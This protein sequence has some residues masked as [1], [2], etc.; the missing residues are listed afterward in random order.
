M[1]TSTNSG[2]MQTYSTDETLEAKKGRMS[3]NRFSKASIL[4]LVLG[5]FMTLAP[6]AYAQADFSQQLQTALDTLVDNP[7]SNF[8]GAILYVSQPDKGT[9]LG[10]AGVAD[11]ETGAPLSPDA[12]FRAGSI[13]KPFVAV[14]VLQLIEEGKLSLETPIAEVLPEAYKTMFAAEDQITVKM[15][16][17][18]SSGIPEWLTPSALEQ[19]SAEPTKVWKVSEFLDLAAAQPAVFAPGEGYGYSNTDY[20]LLGLIIENVTGMSWRDVV[21]ERVI[22]P[23]GLQNTQLPAPGDNSMPEGFMHGYEPLNG[24]MVD[25][26]FT[27]PSMADAAGGGALVTTV[28]DLARFMAGLRAGELFQKQETLNEMMSFIDAPDVGGQVGYGLGLQQYMLP[29][30]LELIGHLGS[31]AGYRAFTGYFPSLDLSMAMAFN[32]QSDPTPI[33]L[34]ALDVVMPE[35]TAEQPDP[36]AALQGLLDDQVREQGILGMIMAVRL[37]DGA[38]IS[39]SSGYTD[40]AGKVAWTMDTQS[41]LGSVTKT[42][43]AVVIMQLVQEGKLSLDDTIEKWFPDQ[44]NGDKI[45]IRMLLSHTSGLANFISKENERDPKWSHEWAPLELI[46]EANKLGPVA[47]PGSKVAHYANTNYFLLGLIIEKV[48][49]NSWEQEVRSRIVEP[50]G[51][52]D[53]AFLGNEGVWGGSMVAGYTKTADGYLSILDIP[54]LP[55]ATTAWAAGAV[56]SS[57]SDLMTFA[58]ALF[59]GK[60]VSKETLSQMATP[61]GKDAETGRLWGFGGATLEELPSAFGMGGDVPGYHAF[62]VGIQDTKFVVA[63]LVNT[64]E[65]DVVSPGL[66]A[67]EYLRKE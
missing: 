33:I 22:T 65:G 31:T 56:V 23:L 36:G 50:L 55:H 4:Y 40:P 2:V 25:L 5:W 30:G 43:T 41:A 14:T 54:N 19:I 46:A 9:W 3:M 57:L 10:S 53:T 66:M 7:D 48:T 28:S 64:E 32:T 67:L 49:G 44:P 1:N 62:F 29:G 8:S 42:F 16:L 26:S 27:D 15:L 58:S 18:H 61:L 35:A 20:N 11:I 17:N 13:M 63:A 47:E 52:K 24:E 37:A 12:S 51:L 21:T 60:L 39:R 59:D 34:A 45:T 6:I 38:V